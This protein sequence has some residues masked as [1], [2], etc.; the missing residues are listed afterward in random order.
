MMNTI[1]F[2]TNQYNKIVYFFLLIY[3]SV[4]EG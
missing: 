1:Y 4:I 2:L 3:D